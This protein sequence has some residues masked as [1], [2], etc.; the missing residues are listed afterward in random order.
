MIDYTVRR[1]KKKK[2]P[3]LLIFIIVVFAVLLFFFFKLRSSKNS[4]VGTWQSEGG[5]I[6]EFKDN[7]EGIVKTTSAEHNFKYEIKENVI[8]I[9][10]EEERATDTDYKFS[11]DKKRCEMTSD[12]GT[13]IFNKK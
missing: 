1:Q 8:S 9:D 3:I 11:C 13:F 4:F 12:R 2:A 7:N 10:F 6:Y 5:T